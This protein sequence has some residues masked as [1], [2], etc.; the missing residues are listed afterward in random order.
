MDTL[1]KDCYRMRNLNCCVFLGSVA[2]TQFKGKCLLSRLPPPYQLGS[3]KF[4]KQPVWTHA[5]EWNPLGNRKSF[6]L[7]QHG[8]F[9]PVWPK[10]TCVMHTLQWSLS[11]ANMLVSL[12]HR[13]ANDPGHSF[14]TGAHRPLQW[15]DFLMVLPGQNLAL[16]TTGIF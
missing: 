4:M 8:S 5:Y 13:Q 14:H 3:G 7:C 15:K 1:R 2:M 6:T 11:S 16:Q 9:H 10:V 12:L